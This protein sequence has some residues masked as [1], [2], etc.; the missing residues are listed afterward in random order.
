M[1][2]GYAVVDGVERVR[3]CAQELKIRIERIARGKGVQIEQG[4]EVIVKA[5]IRF[6]GLRCLSS[7]CDLYW[8]MPMRAGQNHGQGE[9]DVGLVMACG[10]SW[11]SHPSLAQF[12]CNF[13]L[14]R[15][16]DCNCHPTPQ[17]GLPFSFHFCKYL[18]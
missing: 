7:L 15:V 14:Q 11:L 6:L 1:K 18:T 12:G 2:K 9:N 13:L 16:E 17:D 8:Q 10:L 4:R 3:G 5:L